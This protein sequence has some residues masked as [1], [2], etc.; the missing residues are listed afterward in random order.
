MRAPIRSLLGLPVALLIL[1][2]PG[3]AQEPSDETPVLV[4]LQGDVAGVSAGRLELA[5]EEHA[6]VFTDR[7]ARSVRHVGTEHFVS[8]AWGPPSGTFVS[9]PPNAS[10]VGT[11]G[12][13]AIVEIKTATWTEG[14]VSM[15]IELLEGDL[16]DSGD[17]IALT[18][19]AVMCCATHTC[20][21]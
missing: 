19:D 11:D 18:I 15:D 14:T 9:D 13:V 12:D 16:P 20:C 7:P 5:A 2:V 1:A 6:L 21:D 17:R 3:G 10:L 4:V 8:R